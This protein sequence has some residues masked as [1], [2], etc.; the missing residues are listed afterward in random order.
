MVPYYREMGIEVHVNQP[1]RRYD[2]A[3]FFRRNRKRSVHYLRYLKRISDK[4]LFDACINMYSLNEEVNAS[5]LEAA[6]RIGALADAIVCA[7][8]KIAEITRPYANDVFIMEDPLDL[9]HFSTTK[10][11][12]NFDDPVF[13][14]SGEATKAIFLNEHAEVLDG[15][16]V[17]ISKDKIR[18]VPLE[19]EYEFVP[20]TYET[21][22]EAL[23]KCDI[24]FLPRRFDD[25]YNIAHSSFKALVFAGLGL[26]VIASRIPSYVRLAQYYDGLVF[27]EDHHD[28]V[29]AC[30]EVLRK[31]SCDP[32]RVREHY[33]CENQ[34]GRLIEYLQKSL[35]PGVAPPG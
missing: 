25:D 35:A 27:L 17:L 16:T 9:R 5:R 14:W 24:G 30:V 22:P 20:W 10:R 26:P 1:F 8:H 3:I 18:R 28:S 7:S 32:S 31:R 15:R 33:A 13:G 21:F 11:A 23:L 6:K 2:V 29:E 19:F 12:P 34:G 4:V